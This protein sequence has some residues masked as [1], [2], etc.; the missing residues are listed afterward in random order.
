MDNI[1]ELLRAKIEELKNDDVS[2]YDK[3]I[4]KHK[5][6]LEKHGID[7]PLAKIQETV[8]VEEYPEKVDKLLKETEE[9]L[10]IRRN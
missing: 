10:K 7:L 3:K 4:E 9:I 8:M 5:K 1:C 2:D 6:M